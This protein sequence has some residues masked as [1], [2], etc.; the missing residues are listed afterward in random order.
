M[1]RRPPLR[2]LLGLALFQDRLIILGLGLDDVGHVQEAVLPDP[3]VH[4]RRADAR[5]HGRNLSLVDTADHP[6]VGLALDVI[7]L[8]PTVFPHRHARFLRLGADKHFPLRH[9]TPISLVG[10][11]G[12][13]RDPPGLAARPPEP[14]S[15]GA[16]LGPEAHNRFSV[17]CT[18]AHTG[19]A[20]VSG[21]RTPRP[22]PAAPAR[23]PRS[24]GGRGG[25]DS[26]PRCVVCGTPP[27]GPTAAVSDRRTPRPNRT[28][29]A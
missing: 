4:K 6:L 2:A 23:P 19:S 18:I 13:R 7:L 25:R 8:E 16:R 9:S 5:H 15:V 11:T 21:R 17:C 3:D 12:S 24:E 28:A 26:N 20:P 29:R 14:R 1:L 10:P 27:T 22:H